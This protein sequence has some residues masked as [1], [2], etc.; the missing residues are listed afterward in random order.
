MESVGHVLERLNRVLVVVE[1]ELARYVF[2]YFLTTTNLVEN[3]KSRNDHRRRITRYRGR[4][5]G[6]CQAAGGSTEG[7]KHSNR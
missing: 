2:A 1:I 3:L 4:P 7:N 5:Y 6:N